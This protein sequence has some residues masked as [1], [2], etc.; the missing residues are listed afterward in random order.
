MS[1]C[2]N[3]IAD[4]DIPAGRVV[5]LLETQLIPEWDYLVN[6]FRSLNRDSCKYML[7]AQKGKLRRLETSPS[8]D[9]HGVMHIMT[10]TVERKLNSYSNNRTHRDTMPSLIP[11]IA[12]LDRF[13]AS[14][15]L[16]NL[17]PADTLPRSMPI[18]EV[19]PSILDIL[20]RPL[21]G[22]LPSL[23]RLSDMGNPGD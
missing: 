23:S 4:P 14:L 8:S 6:E 7:M 1:E 11:R 16:P 15:D 13:P 3:L 19:V 17:M 2:L 12:Y 18:D 9:P 10:E 21:S 5:L 20:T 22:R